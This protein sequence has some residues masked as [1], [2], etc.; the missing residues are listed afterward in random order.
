MGGVR[1]TSG[2][3]RDLPGTHTPTST[4]LTCDEASAGGAHTSGNT[5][6]TDLTEPIWPTL[7]SHPQPGRRL[8]PS[9]SPAGA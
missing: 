5:F 2:A 8:R 1:G 6:H 3:R 4:P 7:D 9:S